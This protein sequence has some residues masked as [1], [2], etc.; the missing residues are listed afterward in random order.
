MLPHLLLERPAV[1]VEAQREAEL[2]RVL[3]ALRLRPVVPSRSVSVA[4]PDP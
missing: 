4:D 3:A 1:G 2:A